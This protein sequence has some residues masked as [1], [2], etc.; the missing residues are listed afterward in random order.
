MPL[1][2][3]AILLD[4]IRRRGPLSRVELHELTQIRPAGISQLTGE[5]LE[6]GII[7]EAGPSNNPTG[8]KRI[9]LEMNDDAG[10]ILA[11]DFDAERVTA[12][13]LDCRPA[14]IGQPYSEPTNLQGQSELMEQL[15]RCAR[16]VRQ[17]VGDAKRILGVG[18]GDPGVVDSARGLSVLASTIEFW[19]NVPLR[20]RFEAELGIPCV[21][22]DNTRARTMAECMLGAGGR[23]NDMIFIEYGR[24]IGAGMV[25]G[26]KVLLGHSF[27]AGEFGHTHVIEGGPPCKCGSFGCLEALA[28][29]G[30]LEFRLRRA[31]REGGT[32]RCLEM[33]GGD[34]EAITGWQV[35]EAARSGD[36]MS[37]TL[38]EEV[39]RYLGLGVANMVN[40]FNP[41]LIVIDR[42]LALAGQ[43]V[44]DEIVRVVRRQA[45]AYSNREL[46]F[47]FGDL[48][49]E[50]ASLLG[51]GL[52]L[53]E[54]VFE[55]PDL[56]P[57][58]V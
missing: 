25:T 9:L 18:V 15:L 48:G 8:R 22:A 5:L 16:R 36:K 40:L 7:R 27:S 10:I 39:G 32:S 34:P 54:S 50:E 26:G 3:R 12:A 53:L 24:G 29:I 14:V 17:E 13:S 30:A 19:R 28:G 11:V 6:E 47:R 45:L 35:L 33:A 43:M 57:S 56:K 58:R 41:Q 46:E 44:L 52:L 23:S 37:V 51:L 1:R 21:V 38:V 31:I 42:R 49:A 20:D 2:N 55:V 4:L